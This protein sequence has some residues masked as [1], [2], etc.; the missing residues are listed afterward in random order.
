MQR[1]FITIGRKLHTKG[2]VYFSPN[3]TQES[4]YDPDMTMNCTVVTC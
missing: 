2:K 1:L 4:V 3:G